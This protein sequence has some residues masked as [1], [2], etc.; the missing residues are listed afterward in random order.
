[1]TLT[2]NV[3]K[4]L[5]TLN[6]LV[7]DFLGRVQLG[8]RAWRAA[9][10]VGNVVKSRE[11][12]KEM[13]EDVAV[14]GATIITFLEKCGKE[15]ERV[16]ARVLAIADKQ[17]LPRERAERAMASA[18]IAVKKLSSFFKSIELFMTS[19]IR[20]FERGIIPGAGLDTLRV[21]MV[22]TPAL[23]KSHTEAM[24]T[25]LEQAESLLYAPVRESAN[26]S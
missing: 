6:T 7:R 12:F 25:D 20:S 19:I 24:L 26:A 3:E 1:M 11:I 17:K 8:E 21:Y 14:Q 9:D 18:N 13:Q 22:K 16:P 23:E 2:S 10:G 15:I 5:E 4:M